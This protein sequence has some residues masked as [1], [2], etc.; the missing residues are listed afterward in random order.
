MELSI[1]KQADISLNELVSKKEQGLSVVRS[2]HVGN[3]RMYNLVIANAGI[4]MLLVD[5]NQTLRDTN[6]QPEAI[7]QDGQKELLTDSKMTL[8][9]RTRSD[10]D[11]K[12][13]DE[14]HISSLR[15]TF[16]NTNIFSNTEY[17]R[18]N[19]QVAGE[20]ISICVDN[21]PEL[22]IRIAL[23]D[24]TTNKS[25]EASTLAKSS[26][27]IQLQD[28]PR[29][30]KEVA[31]MPN[32]VDIICGFVIEA[33]NTNSDIQ[34]HISGPDMIKYIKSIL[35]NLK[36]IYS[37]L[38]SASFANKLPDNLIVEL[39]PGASLSLATTKDSSA[40]L[41]PL[42]NSIE[43]LDI[44]EQESS[45]KRRQ[46]FEGNKPSKEES[47]KLQDSIKLERDCLIGEAVLA[48]RGAN[49]LLPSND[50]PIYTSQYDVASSGLFV[51]DLLGRLTIARLNKI[52]KTISKGQP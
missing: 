8:S 13:L 14:I 37:L 30:E 5:H 23:P 40:K 35:P 51:P 44:F 27:V 22:F 4:D 6:Y 21:M 36:K 25:F 15:Q 52:M 12:Y 50:D 47:K 26:G 34:F 17:L 48:L 19:E 33:L 3:S 28:D 42:V 38:S 32:E 29:E 39:V 7:I 46:F 31:M 11:N 24:G 16:P 41:I 10:K 20:I 2:A 1:N 9:L 49:E 43:S 18:N 45:R